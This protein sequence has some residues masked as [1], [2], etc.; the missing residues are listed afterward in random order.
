MDDVDGVYE[1]L[2]RVLKRSSKPQIVQKRFGAWLEERQGG[3][4]Q[5]LRA[6]WTLLE[7]RQE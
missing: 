4:A 2:I 5:V 7:R 6:L 3:T 1:Q